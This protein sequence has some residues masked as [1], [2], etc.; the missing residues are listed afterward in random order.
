MQVQFCYHKHH[1]K[2][3]T[4]KGLTHV[5]CITVTKLKK[6][7]KD[8]D[9]TFTAPGSVGPEREGGHPG[10]RPSWGA[11]RPAQ[12][13]NRQRQS[14][15]WLKLSCRCVP[16]WLRMVSEISTNTIVLSV[17]AFSLA[18][19]LADSKQDKPAFMRY[20]HGRCLEFRVSLNEV[21]ICV[22]TQERAGD[23][24]DIQGSE[25]SGSEDEPRKEK[26]RQQQRPTNTYI[27]LGLVLYW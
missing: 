11:V 16:S 1:H 17:E 23:R 6:K 14:E 19:A 24:P 12:E 26:E 13:E 2:G 4:Y 9:R 25:C 5:F 8:F 22:Q 18:C 27:F 7:K 10:R 21:S 20:K 15:G 3:K